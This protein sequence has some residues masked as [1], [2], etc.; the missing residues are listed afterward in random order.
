[1]KLPILWT[2]LALPLACLG[3]LPLS[4]ANAAGAALSPSE[5]DAIV[6]T[7]TQ[8]AAKSLKLDAAKLRLV[9][10]QLKQQ[11]DW[12]F[13]TAQLTDAAGQRFNYAGTDLHDAAQA[14]AVSTLCAALLQRDGSAWRLVDIAVGPTDVAWAP[15]AARHKAPAALFQ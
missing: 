13:L 5:R 8:G 7:A 1:M 10:E 11:G 2:R 6:A 15:W 4:P 3:V 9:P 12:V 14:G